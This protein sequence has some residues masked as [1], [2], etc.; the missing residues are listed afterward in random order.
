MIRVHATDALP[1]DVAAVG[2]PGAS[3]VVVL[4]STRATPQDIAAALD[5][6]LGRTLGTSWL[7]V[8]PV[9]GGG[10]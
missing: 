9:G 10:A 3:E 2:I 5:D 1:E 8:G 7:Y 4:I 6:V